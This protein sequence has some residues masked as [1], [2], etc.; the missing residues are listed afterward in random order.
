MLSGSVTARPAVDID[1]YDV[2]SCERVQNLKPA[3]AVV[4]TYFG[5]CRTAGLGCGVINKPAY[6]S[7]SI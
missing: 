1:G 5:Q 2:G 7:R 6:I 4:L 3:D